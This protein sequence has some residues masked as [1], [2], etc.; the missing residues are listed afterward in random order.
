MDPEQLTSFSIRLWSPSMVAPLT[1]AEVAVTT[2]PL[3]A[4]IVLVSV[5]LA[6]A[7]TMI[8]EAVGTPPL[9]A[10]IVAL[11]M[12]AVAIAPTTSTPPAFPLP[13]ARRF[14]IRCCWSATSEV[15]SLVP[16]L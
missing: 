1:A 5:A 12:S 6:P 7:A 3:S 15:G 14:R 8:P 4:T 9:L 11:S 2:G 10:A 16:Q 13:S